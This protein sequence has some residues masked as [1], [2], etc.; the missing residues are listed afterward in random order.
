MGRCWRRNSLPLLIPCE[1]TPGS[2]IAYSFG[3]HHSQSASILLP[4]SSSKKHHL[5]AVT[6][7][8]VT[9]VK[10]VPSWSSQ[11]PAPSTGILSQESES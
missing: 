5:V 11:T 1:L 9:L 8:N 4:G 3:E 10:P 2:L 6:E 7:M